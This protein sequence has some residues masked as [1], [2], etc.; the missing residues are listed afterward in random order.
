MKNNIFNIQFNDDG[1]ISSIVNP[2]DLF[3]M[4]WINEPFKWGQIRY[5]DYI[6]R[7]NG[8]NWT[9]DKYKWMTAQSV[10]N[11]TKNAIACAFLTKMA[12]ALV[13]M[14]IRLL[15]TKKVELFTTNGQTTKTLPCI[16]TLQYQT[17]FN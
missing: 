12:N 6:Q 10:K 17:I 5:C 14:F 13:L 8:T 3:C 15:L 7:E 11:K 16:F 1:T 9:V 2:N 4:N